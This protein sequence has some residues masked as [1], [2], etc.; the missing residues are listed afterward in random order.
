MR[1]EGLSWPDSSKG[2]LLQ[3]VNPGFDSAIRV[4]ALPN[5]KEGVYSTGRLALFGDEASAFAVVKD[6]GDAFKVRKRSYRQ[7]FVTLFGDCE[8]MLDRFS[9]ADR[10]FRNFAAHVYF[11]DKVCRAVAQVE[12]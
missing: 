4:Y 7:S 11:Y 2:A 5:A 10:K 3:V 6:G 9:R 12:I 8:P 1:F